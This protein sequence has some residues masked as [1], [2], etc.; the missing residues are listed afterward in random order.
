[1]TR[2]PLLLL[3]G[4]LCD[5]TL[6]RHQTATLAD[7]AD[8]TVADL[9][10]DDSV[11]GMA[12]RALAQA[13][14]RFAMA[15]LSMGGYVAQQIMR[16]AKDRVTRLALIDTSARDDT[17][18]Q[19][20]RRESLIELAQTGKFR[21]V[22][23][24]LLPLLI[25]SARLEDEELK[26]AVLGMAARVGRDAFI[27]QQQAIMG[28]PDGR[29]DLAKISCPTLVMCGRQDELTP[30]ALHQEIAAGIGDRARLVVIEDCGHLSP[31]ERPRAVSAVMRYWLQG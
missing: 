3:P 16:M 28:R 24:R 19:R 7:V 20:T 30:P 12:V 29:P 14:E 5:E 27:A 11:A 22:T 10:L 8:I 31:L 23:P 2:I 17:P 9:T 15:G 21:G 4:L 18:E 13:P 6:W 1:M 25:H 26:D